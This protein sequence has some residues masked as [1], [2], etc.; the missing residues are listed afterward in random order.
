MTRAAR[1]IFAFG[2]YSVATGLILVVAPNALLSLLRLAPT[3]EPWI[4]VLGIVVVVMG[5][6]FIAAARNNVTPFFHF[7]VWGRTVVLIGFTA[8]ILLQ[9]APPVLILFGL[10]DAAGAVWTR[11]AL[12]EGAT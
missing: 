9:L 12:R 11:T 1:S 3:T 6:F 10:I 5:S 4:H 2:I 8:L 7:T